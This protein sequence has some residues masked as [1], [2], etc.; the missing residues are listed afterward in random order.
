MYVPSRSEISD[1]VCVVEQKYYIGQKS[2]LSNNTPINV[3]FSSKI[4]TPP[5]NTIIIVDNIFTGPFTISAIK[6][7][8]SSFYALL[9]VE[10]AV[11]SNSLSPKLKVDIKYWALN[12]IFLEG[13]VKKNGKIDSGV[14]FVAVTY[15]PHSTMILKGGALYKKILG[16]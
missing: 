12:E 11:P 9:I 4:K 13:V 3:E 6:Q 10:N 5:N 16:I 8:N 14:E 15:S 2:N 1:K 7:K